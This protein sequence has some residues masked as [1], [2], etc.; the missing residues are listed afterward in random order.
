MNGLM[1]ERMELQ[2]HSFSSFFVILRS[3]ELESLLL[4][5]RQMIVAVGVDKKSREIITETIV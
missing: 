2:L 1:K 4:R 5:A 3:P